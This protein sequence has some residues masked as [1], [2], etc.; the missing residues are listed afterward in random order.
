MG[1]V[2]V[3]RRDGLKLDKCPK[4]LDLIEMDAHT[5]PQKQMT[6]LDDDTAYPNRDGERRAQRRAIAD[7]DDPVSTLALLWFAGALELDQMRM[8]G[9]LLAELQAAVRDREVGIAL[10]YIAA[11]SAPSARHTSS[12]PDGSGSLAFSSMF[13]R[14][15]CTIDHDLMQLGSAVGGVL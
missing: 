12:D 2:G 5:L 11:V 6:A 9:P 1:E 15:G 14:G 7:L 8:T 3:R 4:L 10:R 13:L